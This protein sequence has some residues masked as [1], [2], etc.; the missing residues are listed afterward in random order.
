MLTSAESRFLTVLSDL[1]HCNPFSAERIRLEQRA[2]GRQFEQDSGIAWSRTQEYVEADRPNVVHVTEKAERLAASIRE[3]IVTSD[4]LDEQS[5][6]RYEDLVYYVLYYRWFAVLKPSAQELSESRIAKI[7]PKFLNDFNSFLELPGCRS[8]A[9]HA[10]EH[11]FACLYQVKRAFCHIFHFILGD[12]AP[13]AQL[14][15]TVWQS[16]F[17]HDMRRYRRTLY[18]C[19]RDTSTLITGPSGTGKELVA[20]AIGFSQ[21]WSFDA[22]KQK[23][24]SRSQDAFLP[25]NLSALSPTLIESEL[26]GHRKGAFTGAVADRAGWLERCP[27]SGAVFLDEIGEL[28]P[29]IQVKLLRVLQSRTYSRLGESEE[30]E[31]AGKIITATNRDLSAEIQRGHFRMDL[32]YRLCSDHV[33]TPSLRAQLDDHPEA[34]DGL[35]H[36]LA[37]RIAGDEADSIAVECCRWIREHLPA[38]YPWPGNIRELEQC[39]RN[40]MIRQEY[41]P[42]QLHESGHDAARE[43]SWDH[44]V[45]EMQVN[46]EQLLCRYV[47]WVYAHHPTYE[48]TAQILQLDRRTVK[49][50]IDPDLLKTFQSR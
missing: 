12:S 44:E 1:S 42:Q 38:G 27:P 24:E 35:V 43:T 34:L 31:F 20:R 13:S 39:V 23:F 21:Y 32:Y 10:P 28:D 16:I 36:F 40:I 49:S 5:R 6:S 14:R 30:R 48:A 15:A 2:L 17:T 47:T 9:S 41:I 33:V 29:A 25:L 3:R 8:L 50:K 46:A 11:L 45:S 19:L 26:F 22:Q 7:W 18:S 37:E 4:S